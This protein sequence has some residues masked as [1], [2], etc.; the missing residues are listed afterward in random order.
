MSLSTSRWLMNEA[1]GS[2]ETVNVIVLC[3]EPAALLQANG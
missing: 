2:L 1:E 3:A